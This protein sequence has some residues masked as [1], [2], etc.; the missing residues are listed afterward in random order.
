MDKSLS[1]RA[2]AWTRPSWTML[3]NHAHAIVCLIRN[4]RM[5]IRDIANEVGLTER[6][7][8][9]ILDELEYAGVI[10]RIKEGRSNM[11]LLSIGSASRHPLESDNDLVHLFRQLC[12]LGDGIGTDQESSD[13]ANSTA[14]KQAP[15]L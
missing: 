12:E 3:T 5:R 9:R 2:A 10:R 7:V 15:A 8:H 13:S 1:D 14:D 6:M 11:Y 4:P